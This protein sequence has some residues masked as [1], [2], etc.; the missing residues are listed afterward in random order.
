M[1]SSSVCC[2]P[3]WISSLNLGRPTLSSVLQLVQALAGVLGLQHLR[4]G[5]VGDRLTGH[6]GADLL[7]RG[8]QGDGNLLAHG[9]EGLLDLDPQGVE[10]SL[11]LVAEPAHR[12]L[13]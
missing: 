2:T 7:A 11:H 10:G 13:Q 6:L 12:A 4:Q 8:P 5:V 1:T 3:A 9:S